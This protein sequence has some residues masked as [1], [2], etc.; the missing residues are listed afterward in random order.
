MDNALDSVSEG[1]PVH[2]ASRIWGV[3]QQTL[4][5]RVLGHVSSSTN[6]MGRHPLFSEEQERNLVDHI[7]KMA[8][9]GYGYSRMQ[10][11]YLATDMIEFTSG[12]RS[13]ALS[14]RWFYGFMRRWPELKVVKPRSLELMRAK[15]ATQDVVDSYYKELDSILKKYDLIE[16]PERIYNI[17]E[18][19]FQ[20]VH[21]PPKVVAGHKGKPPAVTS[22]RGATT[23]VISCGS[24][25]GTALPP[26]FIFKGK[27]LMAELLEGSLPGTQATVSDSGWSNSLIFKKYLQEHFLKYAH[28][29][30][31][32]EDPILI[33]YDGHAS[34]V[35]QPVV[36]W[37]RQHNI[38]LMVIPPHT[39][40]FLQPLDVGIFGP[41]KIAYNSACGEFLRA[42]PG[43]SITRYN[44]CELI[45]KAYSK[46]NTPSN[47]I[48]AFRRTGVCPLNKNVVSSSMLAPSIATN[49]QASNKS[50]EK[51]VAEFLQDHL[52]KPAEK[53]QKRRKTKY[54]GFGGKAITEDDTFEE[55]QKRTKPKKFTIPTKKA[56]ATPLTPAPEVPSSPPAASTPPHV[57]LNFMIHS[58]AKV[59]QLSPPMDLSPESEIKLFIG[60]SPPQS[61]QP[62]PSHINLLSPN[63]SFEESLEDDDGI[64]C[65]CSQRAP[66]AF[67]K[68]SSLGILNWA[69]CDK[70]N[71]WVH[72]KYCTKEISIAHNEAFMCPCCKK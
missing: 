27:R 26:F 61:P 30:E 31:N 55:L 13:K 33:M 23:T 43:Q 18:T 16:H 57:I 46:V 20:N 56:P 50:K 38:I 59:Q 9:F 49:P 2:K 7:T 41:M 35:G 64:C 70:C 67:K 12:K 40:H 21:S 71:H 69:Q 62:G 53:E 22:P 15:A 60:R 39:S 11:I 28:R 6:A 5:D 47:L 14:T 65:V 10:V 68:Q 24:A 44:I 19:G 4:R 17:D 58:P 52:P 66:E 3:P 45:C 29:G 37:A 63:A 72:L 51:D 34:H 8:Q 36:E 48:A 1:V 42:H 25:I 54:E 32:A